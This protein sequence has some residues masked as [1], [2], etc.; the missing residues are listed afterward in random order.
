[1]RLPRAPRAPALLDARGVWVP[2]P[3]GAWRLR[4]ATLAAWGGEVVCIA[5]AD[6]GAL[7]AL[8]ACL[9]GAPTWGGVVRARPGWW[10]A[11]RALGPLDVRGR[12]AAWLARAVRA[13]ARRTLGGALV[14][15]LTIDDRAEC[16]ATVHQAVAL[17][18]RHVPVRCVALVG[19]RIVPPPRSVD[20]PPGRS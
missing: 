18:A 4:G 8:L 2:G 12:S 14:L 3:D 10:R 11:G 7:R 1:M 19:G 20:P 5:G 13:R 9:R 17:A 15:A 16:S 6:A